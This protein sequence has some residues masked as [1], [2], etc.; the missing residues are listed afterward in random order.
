VPAEDFP[1]K[2]GFLQIFYELLTD[3]DILGVNP[4]SCIN[5][6]KPIHGPYLSNHPPLAD[7]SKGYVY[8]MGQTELSKAHNSPFFH[9]ENSDNTKPKPLLGYKNFSSENDGKF[10]GLN[11]DHKIAELALYSEGQY[12]EWILS[13]WGRKFHVEPWKEFENTQMHYIKAHQFTK[14]EHE[15]SHRKTLERSSKKD[16]GRKKIFTIKERNTDTPSNE[17]PKDLQATPKA[18]EKPVYK[19]GD[20]F[21][22]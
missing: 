3:K 12:T 1:I 18:K 2:D 22:S 17:K 13:G 21:G 19:E 20:S 4:P 10:R 16:S 5:R 11:L 14:I 15:N 7:I 8:R 9:W 6:N